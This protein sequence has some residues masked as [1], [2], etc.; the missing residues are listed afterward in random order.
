[1]HRVNSSKVMYDDLQVG[2]L[3]VLPYTSWSVACCMDVT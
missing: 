3:H 1:M 2:A